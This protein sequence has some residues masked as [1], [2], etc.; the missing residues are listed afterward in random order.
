MEPKP[1]VGFIGLGIMGRP[2]ARHILRAGYPL[3]VHNRS[4]PPIESLVAEGARE[5]HSPAELA[6]Q[7]DCVITCL[8]DDA[9]VRQVWWTGENAALPAMR[10]DTLAID[11]GTTSPSLAQ[12]LAAVARQHGVHFLD[13]P[14]TGGQWGAEA[15]TLTIM[16]GGEPTAY[17]RALPILQAMG[18]KIVHVGESGKGQLMK[19]ANQIAVAIGILAVA[20]SLLFAEQAGLDL[21]QT[22]E[23]L[24]SG[25]AGSWAMENLGRR[26][27][28]RDFEPGFMVQLQQKDLQMVL[29]ESRRSQLPL[30]GTALVNQLYRHLERTGEQ[31]LGTQA[32][33]LVLERLAGVPKVK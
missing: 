26:I 15:G 12:E 25:A 17:E 33:I 11:M 5:A 28:Q 3:I 31:R 1:T 9:T 21:N 4:R 13:A 32:L 20:E 18:K 7:C 8:P 6:A 16:V 22:I 27:A 24:S 14:V 29:D 10:P 23:V 19:L 2:M 30:L